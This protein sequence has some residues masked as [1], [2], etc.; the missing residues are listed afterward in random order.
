VSRAPLC[1]P[2]ALQLTQ[3][4]VVGGSAMALQVGDR[5]IDGGDS[6]SFGC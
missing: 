5:G 4:V 6:L 3:A 1:P 2:F